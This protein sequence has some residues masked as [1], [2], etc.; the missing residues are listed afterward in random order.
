MAVQL[1][2]ETGSGFYQFT[3]T[4]DGVD[5]LFDVRWNERD[6]AWYFDLLT[7]DGEMIGSGNKIV[8]GSSPGFRTAD[9]RWPNGPFVVTDTSESGLDATYEDIGTRVLVFW[10]TAEEFIAA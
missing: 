2:F 3:S 9:E 10:Y 4:L 5:Y 1:P 8:L 6:S 7:V